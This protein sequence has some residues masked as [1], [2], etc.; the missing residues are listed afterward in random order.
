MD[1]GR[2]RLLGMWGRFGD[3]RVTWDSDDPA[4]PIHGQME[5]DG[6]W[7]V[8]AVAGDRSFSQHSREGVGLAHFRASLMLASALAYPE[9]DLILDGGDL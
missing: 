5:P 2:I 8:T 7:R 9:V 1:D 6:S 4:R 3:G